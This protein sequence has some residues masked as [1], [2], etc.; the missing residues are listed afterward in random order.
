M[1]T[2]QYKFCAAHRYWNPDWNEEKNFHEFGDDIRLHG[3]NYDLYVTVKGSI[4]N[5]TGFIISLKKLNDI[6][7]EHVIRVFDHMQIEKDIPWF[8]NKQPSTENMVVF[9]WNQLADNIPAPAQLHK[10]KLRETNSIY[11]EY[12]GE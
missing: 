10:I 2:K 4:N 6:V 8:H 12:Y 9:I 5:E 7:F 3:H 1:I 11:T